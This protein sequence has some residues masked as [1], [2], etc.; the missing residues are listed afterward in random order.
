MPVTPHASKQDY[1]TAFKGLHFPTSKAAVL[2]AGR[3]K[4]GIDR[5]VGRVLF[6]LPERKFRTLDELRE[7]VRDV[8]RARGVAEG[9]LPL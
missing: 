2:N 3:D 7:A 4:G 9:D 5:E 6:S 1:E 8:Y